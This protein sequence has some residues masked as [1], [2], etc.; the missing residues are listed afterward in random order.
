MAILISFLYLILYMVIVGFIGWVI[1]AVLGAAPFIPP[2]IKDIITK[3]VY[4]IVFVV[5]VILLVG[6]LSSMV[7]FTAGPIGPMFPLFQRR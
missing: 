7:G 5:C 6:W 2:P 4:F 3:I 1:L